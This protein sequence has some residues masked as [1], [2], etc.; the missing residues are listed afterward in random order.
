[1]NA[2]TTQIIYRIKCSGT[3]TEQYEEQLR[4]VFGTD[5]RHALEQ[6][7]TIALDEESTFVDRHGRT[8]TWEM[9]AIKDLQPVDLQN[10]TLL[11]STVKE[12]E[13]VGVH[14]DI[15]A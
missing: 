2:Y 3:Q 11:M 15:E 5:E 10:G 6:A 1:M 13:P 12:V 14:A 4:L 7:R 9:V 8:V